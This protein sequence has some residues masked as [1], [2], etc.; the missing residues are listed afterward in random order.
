MSRANVSAYPYQHVASPGSEVG[1]GLTIREHATIEMA[2]AIIGTAGGPCLTGF[3]GCEPS[4][5][6]IAAKMADAL[7]A[8]LAKTVQP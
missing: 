2:K 5:A 3:H 6:A 7:I 8:E 4:I 1:S